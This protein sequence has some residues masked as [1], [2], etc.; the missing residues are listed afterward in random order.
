MPSSGRVVGCVAERR[1][2]A[3]DVR[4]RDRHVAGLIGLALDLRGL[5]DDA[6]DRRD[7]LAQRDRV[8]AAEVVDLV[9]R[10]AATRSIAAT[11]AGDDVVDERVVAARRAVAE[12]RDRPVRA[13]SRA[14]NFAIAMSGRWRGPYTVKNRSADTPSP[15]RSRY[16]ESCSSF[17][18]LVAA[19]GD[20]GV[21]H[22]S[23]SRNAATSRA[24]LRA[25]HRAR[26]R[27]HEPR[28]ARA[29]ACAR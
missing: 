8:R 22:G 5:A 13:R 19:Y 23:S 15:N 14:T 20:A 2:R 24:R 27:E 16:V 12:Q 21:R 7:Q 10:R 17:I 18:R 9:L 3:I 11:D 1:A 25:V 4:V 28:A 29:R 6:L 26:R